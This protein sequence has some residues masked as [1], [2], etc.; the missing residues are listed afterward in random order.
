[1][2]LWGNQLDGNI[3]NS[4]GNL[5]ELVELA[6][7]QNQLSG[8][9][10]DFTNLPNLERFECD[11]NNLS[12]AIPDFTN[13]PN[14][15]FFYCY[16]NQLSG[17]IPDFSNL[18]NL[19]GFYCYNNQLSGSIPDFTNLPNLEFFYCY[20]NQLSGSIPDFSNLP[21]LEIFICDNNE[22]SGSIP[23]FTD[24]CPNLRVLWYDE[25]RFTFEGILPHIDANQ[26]L[27]TANAQASFDSLRYAPQD[28]IYT[29]TLISASVGAP[30]TVDLGIDEGIADNVYQWYKDGQPYTTITGDNQLVFSSLQLS[31]AGV[32]TVEVTNP[33]APELTLESFPITLQVEQSCSVNS[34]GL[35]DVS[36]D[37]NGTPNN[38]ED[39]RIT[40]SLQPQG[41]ELGDRYAISTNGDSVS[42]SQ[43]NYATRQT[44]AAGP[45]SAGGGD[46]I[47]RISDENDSSCFLE[48]TLTDP[49][50]CSVPEPCDV[51]QSNEIS[52]TDLT[53]NSARLSSSRTGVELFEWRYRAG[54]TTEWTSIAA[55]SS[56]SVTVNDLT[57]SGAYEVQLRVLC[58]SGQW[59][60]WSATTT[61]TTMASCRTQDSLGLV[62]L[63]EATNGPNWNISWDLNAPVDSWDGIT[64][65]DNGCVEQLDLTGNNLNGTLPDLNLSNLEE[66]DLDRN[67][68]NGPLPD[69]SNMP[70]LELLTLSGNPLSG[71]LPD[72][73]TLPNLE[74]LRC[75]GTQLSG[76]I[77]DFS[78]LPRLK[79]LSVVEN[80]LIGAIPDF[81][82]LAD[83]E[84]LN[85]SNN[86]L[87]GTIPEFS[88]LPNLELFN[89]DNNQFTFQ[90]VIPNLAAVAATVAS[91]FGSF[92]YAPQD[93]I[94]ADTIFIASTGDPFTIDLGIDEG[95]S[96]NVYNWYKDGA[97]YRTITGNNDLEFTNLQPS[98]AGLYR[99]EVTNP[100]APELTLYSHDI[101]LEVISGG[102]RLIA[103]EAEGNL[104]E[105]I[106]LPIMVENADRLA[107]LQGQINFGKP[108][109]LTLT[110][111]EA[112]KMT[113]ELNAE[114]G[115]FS[116][117]DESGEG[118]SLAPLDTLFYLSIQLDGPRGDS[119]SVSFSNSPDFDLEAYLFNSSSLEFVEADV[120]TID[121]EV[122]IL[123][124]YTIAGQV[125]NY[126][127]APIAGVT[128]TANITEADGSTS[129]I[130]TVT[131]EQGNYLFEDV[132]AGAE[133]LLQP[134]R[135]DA[136][137]AGMN[138]SRD[139]YAMQAY[140]EG[141]PS[142]LITSPLQ[143]AAG[144]VNCDGL[145]NFD[146]MRLI[147]AVMVGLASDFPAC[148]P[149][150]FVPESEMAFFSMGRTYY[151]N[152]PFPKS[153]VIDTLS[154]NTTVNFMGGQTG[155]LV[156]EGDGSD[157]RI[158]VKVVPPEVEGL[159]VEKT[160]NRLKFRDEDP[161]LGEVQVGDIL[162]SGGGTDAAPYG[163][164]RRVIG[165]QYKKSG[166]FDFLTEL[167][168]LTEL[169]EYGKIDRSF[170]LIEPQTIAIDEL[171]Y[172]QDEQGSTTDDQVRITGDIT[173]TVSMKR[174]LIQVSDEGD[175]VS[176][177]PQITINHSLECKIGLLDKSHEIVETIKEKKLPTIRIF[178]FG[179]PVVIRPTLRLEVGA[180]FEAASALNM[181]YKVIGSYTGTVDYS[182]G[183]GVSIA[184]ERNLSFDSRQVF[185]GAAAV[186]VFVKP[187][188]EIN[189]YEEDFANVQFN[190]K[191]FL[192][193]EASTS[194]EVSDCALTAGI[195]LGAKGDFF[196]FEEPFEKDIIG[197]SEKIAECEGEGKVY[198]GNV[199]L[200]SQTD[201]DEFASES[202]TK[203]IGDLQIGTIIIDPDNNITSLSQ[204]K[205]ITE[206]TG[207]LIVY[208]CEKLT[209]FDGLKNLIKLGGELRFQSNPELLRISGLSNLTEINE[210]VNITNNHKLQTFDGLSKLR[211]V[212]NDIFISL[213]HELI[214]VDGFSGLNEIG[215]DLAIKFS[216]KLLDLNG[217]S[218]LNTVRGNLIIIS[219]GKLDDFC[220]LTNLFNAGGL[221]GNFDASWNG[222][223][224]TKEMI[225]SGNCKR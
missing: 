145:I 33:G 70:E 30:L 196:L 177:Q 77:P 72:F 25:N 102:I 90:N 53:V 153:T 24:N 94:Y 132:P 99:V 64:F 166:L 2:F 97:E 220:G 205:S 135:T 108:D 186:E 86:Q 184:G 136:Q 32:Y 8:P 171:I 105:T 174:L 62:E 91:N 51:P 46:I 26:Q 58:E 216:P 193:G 160:E 203:I 127:Q 12:G 89:F 152:Y 40:F 95:M 201:V 156:L 124:A 182:D 170:A 159:L 6:I 98:D 80:Q 14:L 87:S 28:S 181:G 125:N 19:R 47:I 134:S 41:L 48:F 154:A 55:F 190:T 187:L 78:N 217:L 210:G 197:Y 198:E 139:L 165:I 183:T 180:S 36:C 120:E 84:R 121:G 34:A 209:N 21:N 52:I 11:N 173:L 155:D 71:P 88:N 116:F 15:E 112:A 202:F 146:D 221:T 27:I 16:N 128:I 109:I 10:P 93:S 35:Q 169:L 101:T 143:M 57:E 4:L 22:L 74:V 137:L 185:S 83:L 167:A 162:V 133:V 148:Q 96:S 50:S 49:G 130:Q 79:E 31:D 157:A 100:E 199:S 195:Q 3:P 54:G 168:D 222:I 75:N 219:N 176:I 76:A 214:N 117:F 23:D 20:N 69:F 122:R 45:G 218:N 115:Q 7:S 111:I 107:A 1:M 110:G 119:S 150:F 161:F 92:S 213:D 126:T 44:F 144:D 141:K 131:D 66:L 39:D 85:C 103:G 188:L 178:P 204:L 175:R 61:F 18:P 118:L 82:N 211:I 81:S 206:I 29:D 9:I 179:V 164:L 123:E 200:V 67:Q 215:G 158:G 63:Y 42:P 172:D 212:R 68:L 147:Q 73:S 224:P 38:L 142:P 207:D 138:T 149:W 43:G 151:P 140:L 65:N 192:R 60:D 189:F 37:D 114:N 225:L 17:S 191:L 13:L 208:N 104:G 163:Y 56:S 194:E 129:E 223:N 106:R 59:S 113:V 5:I